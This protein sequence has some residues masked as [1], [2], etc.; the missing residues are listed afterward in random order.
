MRGSGESTSREN[1]AEARGWRVGFLMTGTH[2]SEDKS[3]LY[4]RLDRSMKFSDANVNI[5][6]PIDP[7][8][9]FPLA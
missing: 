8:R 2:P 7:A 9:G 4:W 5:S 6:S 3:Y 1:V